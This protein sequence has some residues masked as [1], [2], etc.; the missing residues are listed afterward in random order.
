VILTVVCILAILAIAY[1]ANR[2]VEKAILEMRAETSAR[3][4]ALNKQ[5]KVF[6]RKLAVT[7]RAA[8]KTVDASRATVEEAR[9]LNANTQNFFSDR[10][11]QRLLDRGGE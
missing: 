9:T 8:A 3:E 10:R 6:V 2:K 4:A 1:L 11:V 5:A 7:E